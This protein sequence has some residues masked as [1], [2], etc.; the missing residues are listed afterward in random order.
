MCWP[1]DIT[2]SISE[3]EDMQAATTRSASV[4]PSRL[5]NTMALAHSHESA[6]STEQLCFASTE[7]LTIC[8]LRPKKLQIW[9]ISTYLNTAWPK[10]HLGYLNTAWPKEHLGTCYIYAKKLVWTVRL[11]R[12]GVNRGWL[13]WSFCCFFHIRKSRCALLKTGANRS[14]YWPRPNIPP[15]IPP[16][17]RW[18]RAAPASTNCFESQKIKI[19]GPAYTKRWQNVQRT[20]KNKDFLLHRH[21]WRFS[22]FQAVDYGTCR[23]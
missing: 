17:Q 2:L 4:A 8:Y 19:F 7:S 15:N 9:H 5:A 21:H 22:Q 18:M 16:S 14:L 6:P 20:G 13:H 1:S 11:S 23:A 10:E 12:A 3:Y